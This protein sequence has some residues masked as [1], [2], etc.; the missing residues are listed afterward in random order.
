MKAL[1][2]TEPGFG[3][4]EVLDREIPSPKAD[5]V[6]IKVQYAGICGTDVHTYEGYYKVN[7]P[8][9]LGHEFSGEVVEV[10]ANVT[11]FKVGDRVT[12]ETTYYI[13][14]ECQ[15]CQSGDYNLCN[16]RKGLGTQQNGG[17]T[18]YLVARAA[19]VHRLPDNVSYKAASMT[20]PLACA[21]HAVSKI[22]I[23]ADDVVVVMGPGPIG[24]LVAQ[25][26]KSKGAEVVITGLDNDKARLDKANELHLDHVVNIQ[27]TDLKAY[28]NNI[29][30]G[31]GANVVLECSGAVPA[32]KQGLD[33]LRKKGQYVQVGIFK[34]PEIPFDLEK[35][36]QKE[37]RVVGSRSQKPADWEPSLQLLSSGDVNAEALITSELDITQWEEGYN[38][39]KG[40]EGIKV[41]LRPIE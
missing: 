30:D 19:S 1:V 13:C 36:V 18:Q 25:V 33:L 23:K 20:E 3:N 31:Y 27:N 32:A 40:G 2:K 38:H 12:S 14:G 24:L 34:D 10:G 29:T 16:H 4:L 7:F 6:K 9:T 21:H 26:V 11:D 17:F 15:Y 8:V 35:I 37:I 22:D 39:I 28:V 5:E 41:L